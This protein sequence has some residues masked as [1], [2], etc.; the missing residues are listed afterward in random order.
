MRAISSGRRAWLWVCLV[1]ALLAA[2]GPATAQESGGGLGPQTRQALARGHTLPTLL[3]RAMYESRTIMVQAVFAATVL[4][5][6]GGTGGVVTTGTLTQQAAGTLQFRYAAQPPDKLVV[7][8]A[9][10][11][12]HELKVTEVR[13]DL[14]AATPEA[15][16][17]GNHSLAYEHFIPE[18]ASM[19]VATRSVN[20][21]W[22]YA[23]KGWFVHENTRF[24]TDFRAQGT[25]WFQN[26]MSG[27]E[28]KN[29]YAVQGTIRGG[30]LSIAIK[31]EH[32]FRLVSAQW[33]NRRQR[34]VTHSVDVN[35]NT[36]A[37]GRDTFRWVDAKIAKV[38]TNGRPSSVNE[39]WQA[40]GQVLR[41]DRPFGVYRL[42]TQPTTGKLV[43]LLVA[44]G[45]AVELE[46]W[47]T[48]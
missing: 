40:T 1:P 42:Q 10:R 12:H 34:T 36:L 25:Y 27:A 19:Q 29:R 14:R 41:N 46:S 9:G 4:S 48:R 33:V 32:H 20:G 31:E 28:N 38:F 18:Q 24:A 39:D 17:D 6:R 22:T 30:G 8:L 15:F 5:G 2:G 23:T 7:K 3:G 43:F 45:D 35:N 47:N 16:L 26:D 37:V 44:G 13:G 11:K 21:N